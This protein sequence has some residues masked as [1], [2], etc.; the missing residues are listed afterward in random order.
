M[1]YILK[2]RLGRPKHNCMAGSV[3]LARAKAALYHL[4]HRAQLIL[5]NI[6]GDMKCES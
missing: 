6:L 3:L 4:R 5:E 2:G 1:D